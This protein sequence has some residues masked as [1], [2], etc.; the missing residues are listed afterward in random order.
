MIDFFV[1]KRSEMVEKQLMPRGI[2]NRNVLESMSAVPRHDFVPP[3]L[4]KQAYDDNPLPIGYQQTISQPYI[5]AFMAQAAQLKPTDIVLEIGTGCGYAAA[6]L[7]KLVKKVYSIEFV[8][9]L[10][11]EAKKRLHTL[12]YS[13]IVVVEGDGS[14]GLKNHAPFNAILVTAGAPIIPEPL[15]EQLAINGRL[16][17]PV[18]EHAHQK[19]VRITHLDQT[20]YQEERL[21]A[22]RFVPLRG[23]HGWQ[24]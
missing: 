13:N 4:K 14:L 17:I 16:I 9:E 2:T 3:A 7:S 21:Q 15:K 24:A 1:Q 6:V 20:H 23:E 10:A 19:L 8:P 5:V 12:G 11:L 22:V 18:G